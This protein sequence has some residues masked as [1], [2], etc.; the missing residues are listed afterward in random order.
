M[1]QL[2]MI[3]RD[4]TNFIDFSHFVSEA[5]Y[6]QYYKSTTA[7]L[8]NS[9]LLRR[10]EILIGIGSYLVTPNLPRGD[11][12]DGLTLKRC[13]KS[14]ASVYLRPLSSLAFVNPEVNTVCTCNSLNAFINSC[15]K[16]WH[17][18]IF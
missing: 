17:V 16:F 1:L 2:C 5:Y 13:L 9:T 18:T 15:R 3:M 10:C 4:I 11:V 6:S 7:S 8:N 14:T 12:L